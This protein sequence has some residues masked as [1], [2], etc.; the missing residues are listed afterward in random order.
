MPWGQRSRGSVAAPFPDI[1]TPKTTH[2]R[3]EPE[4]PRTPIH[5]PWQ[6]VQI[7]RANRWLFPVA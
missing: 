6:L 4:P 2:Q 7:I 5:R 3:A 1:S